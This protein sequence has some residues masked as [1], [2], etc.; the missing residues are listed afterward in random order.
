MPDE[1]IYKKLTPSWTG[2][3][4]SGAHSNPV[5][6]TTFHRHTYRPR[7]VTRN[8]PAESPQINTKPDYRQGLSRVPVAV[9]NLFERFAKVL[10]GG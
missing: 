8:A 6:A 7:A 5:S 3:N 9:A 2:L 4:W 10:N 1:R